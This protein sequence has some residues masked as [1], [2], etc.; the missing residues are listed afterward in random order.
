MNAKNST[1]WRVTITFEM[2]GF[3]KSIVKFISMMDTK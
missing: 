1:I 3:A 2:T